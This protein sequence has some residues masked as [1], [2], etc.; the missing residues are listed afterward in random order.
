MRGALYTRRISIAKTEQ[1]EDRPERI[2][3]EQND[4]RFK[5]I[6]LVRFYQ[7]VRIPK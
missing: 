2:I 6:L 5:T 3:W 7:N 4:S 1:A